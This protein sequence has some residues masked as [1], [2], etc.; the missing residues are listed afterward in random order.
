MN[1]GEYQVVGLSSFTND[2]GDIGTN[3]FLITPF[4]EWE[5]SRNNTLGFKTVQEF[6]YMRVNAKPGDIVSINWRKGFQGKAVIGSI[7]VIGKVEK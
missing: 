6:T 3:L 1:V 7:D 4:E 2:K 5:S